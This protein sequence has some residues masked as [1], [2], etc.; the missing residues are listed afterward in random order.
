MPKSWIWSHLNNTFTQF[1]SDSLANFRWTCTC[2]F[3]SRDTIRALQDFSPSLC[4]VLPIV[5]L[6]TIVPATLIIDKI[7]PC[8]SGLIPHHSH[9]HWNSS[10]WDLAWS[11]RPKEIELFC[12]SSI[13]EWLHQLLSP[14]H[15]AAWR[16]SWSP[17]QP[18]VGLQSRP[19]HPW[20][21]LWFWPWWRV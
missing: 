5:F 9:D 16:W 21:A 3:L 4:S 13:Y 17:F 19:W 11:P 1:S 14:S 6:V 12:V 2:A 7:L 20:T 8:S 10:R 18:C 15:Q